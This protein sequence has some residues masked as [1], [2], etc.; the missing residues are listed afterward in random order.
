M[1]HCPS[2]SSDGAHRGLMSPALHPS[3]QAPKTPVKRRHA[4]GSWTPALHSAAPHAGGRWER[5]VGGLCLKGPGV[6]GSQWERRKR[7]ECS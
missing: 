6:G 7:R 4:V 1:P 3:D 5:R 2:C